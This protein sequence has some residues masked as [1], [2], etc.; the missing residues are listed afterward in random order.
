MVQLVTAEQLASHLQQDLDRASAEQA[1]ETASAFVESKTGLAFTARTATVR[2]PAT[3]A[4]E[5]VVPLRPLRAVTSVSI[6][7]TTYTDFEP[8]DGVLW[9]AS[10]WRTRFGA[11]RVEVTVDYGFT[12]VPDDIQGVVR[13]VA[14]T[15]YEGRQ[16]VASEG[17]DDYR[18]NYTGELSQTSKETLAAYGAGVG[19]VRLMSR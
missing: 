17:V 18:A 16:G 10:G 3:S 9:R 13:E 19:T 6:G 8:G 7:G 11:Q 4:L 2:L 12:A 5:L 1:I 14:A 15:I